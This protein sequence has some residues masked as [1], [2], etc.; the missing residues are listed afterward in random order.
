MIMTLE[1]Q[2]AHCNKMGAHALTADPT[3]GPSLLNRRARAAKASL[4]DE[5]AR[6][7]K[8]RCRYAWRQ[9]SYNVWQPKRHTHSVV[10]ATHTVVY[11]VSNAQTGNI[12]VKEH[13]HVVALM[14]P[15]GYS[16]YTTAKPCG[17]TCTPQWSHGWHEAA[18]MA[19]TR[20]DDIASCASSS[21]RRSEASRRAHW[22]CCCCSG[23]YWRRQAESLC[24]W[25]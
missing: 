19:H 2:H 9:P 6:G 1:L 14:A 4:Q 11:V 17:G 7:G 12:M 10:Y 20:H 15:P 18:A 22:R 16:T 21:S 5:V 13:Q 23:T 3:P 25:R 8:R 24:R